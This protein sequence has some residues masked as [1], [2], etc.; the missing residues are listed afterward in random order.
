MF[1]VLF[2]L[3][4]RAYF[5]CLVHRKFVSPQSTFSYVTNGLNVAVSQTFTPGASWESLLDD[6]RIYDRA[7]TPTEVADL[8]TAGQYPTQNSG[9]TVSIIKTTTY[10]CV[11][12]QVI[13]EYTDGMLGNGYAYAS[14]VDESVALINENNEIYYCHQNHLYSVE[15]IT[16]E[17]A[18]I[19]ETYNYDAYGKTFIYDAANNLIDESAIS[20]PYNFTGRRI[21]NETQLYYFRARY[22]DVDLGRFM[23]RYPKRVRSEINYPNYAMYSPSALDGY[24]DGFNLYA[25]YYIPCCTDAYGMVRTRESYSGHCVYCDPAGHDFGEQ[26]IDS[27]VY[28]NCGLGKA[29]KTFTHSTTMTI[30]AR[31]LD[32]ETRHTRY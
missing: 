24:M 22:Y 12:A 3:I 5:P 31:K 18:Q 27:P 10:I 11:G 29:T 13:Q 9:T 28:Y 26:N 20:Q 17:H 4:H 25:G 30:S 2:F 16:D 23:N 1:C 7:L 15:A 6:L 8:H 14:C 21:D 19:V 32:E